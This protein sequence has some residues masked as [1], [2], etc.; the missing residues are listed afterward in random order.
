M[1]D[2]NYLRDIFQTPSKGAAGIPYD[3]RIE[4]AKKG[5][6]KKGEDTAKRLSEAKNLLNQELKLLIQQML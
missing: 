2:V 3:E 1:E 4:R 6:D 5:W